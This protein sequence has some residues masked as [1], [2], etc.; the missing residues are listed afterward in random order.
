[1]KAVILLCV[2]IFAGNHALAQ[3]RGSAQETQTLGYWVDPSTGLMWA[4]K[5][6]GKAVTWHKAASYCRN[7]RLAGYSD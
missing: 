5:D 2:A 3:D 6:N 4:G 1:M 7:T